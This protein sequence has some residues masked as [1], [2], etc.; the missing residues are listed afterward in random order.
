MKKLLISATFMLLV[1]V[2]ISAQKL[3]SGSLG[4]LKGEKGISLVFDYSK[5]TYRGMSLEG[6]LSSEFKVDEEKSKQ[7]IRTQVNGG[8]KSEFYQKFVREFNNVFRKKADALL[9]DSSEPGNYCLTVRVLT[10]DNKNNS[11]SV[12]DIT[13]NGSAEVLAQIALD[14]KSGHFGSTENL[15]GDAYMSGG[16]RLAKFILKSLR[17]MKQ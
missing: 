16:E 3:V 14:G 5:T 11:T 10:F 2:T 15:M 6:F 13:K 8:K 9:I 7:D 1:A 17:A 12:V 4:F